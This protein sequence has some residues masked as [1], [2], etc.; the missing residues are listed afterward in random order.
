MPAVNLDDRYLIWQLVAVKRGYAVSWFDD[1]FLKG[2][3]GSLSGVWPADVSCV[4]N[5]D[6][7]YGNPVISDCLMNSGRHL[8]VSSRLKS[9]LAGA[10]GPDIE[11]WPIQIRDLGGHLLGEPYFFVHLP[12]PHR[13]LDPE[14]TKERLVFTSDPGRPLCRISS[15]DPVMLVSWPLANALAD[16]G[17]IGFRFMGLFDYGIQG[18]LPPHIGRSKVEALNARLRVPKK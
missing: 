9:F 17:F 15:F 18:E 8:L 12:N 4:L 10:A 11:Y 13:C 2:V 14:A 16:E 1:A 5:L 7:G 3:R 6:R